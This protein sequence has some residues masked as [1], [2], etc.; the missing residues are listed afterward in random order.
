MRSQTSPL[1][2]HTSFIFLLK[3]GYKIELVERLLEL[4]TLIEGKVDSNFNNVIF[5]TI[6]PKHA[7]ENKFEQA[8]I[9]FIEQLYDICDYISVLFDSQTVIY[10]QE[11]SKVVYNLEREFRALIEISFLKQKGKDW[12]RIFYQDNEKE[13]NRMD[14]RPDVLKKLDNPLDNRD[15]VDLSNFVKRNV[16]T[17]KNTIYQK[18]ERI[19]YLFA[20]YKEDTQS[21]PDNFIHILDNLEE[22]KKA[23]DFK[24]QGLSYNNLYEHLTPALSVEWKELYEKRNL[25]AHNYCLLTIE[26]L[27]RFIYL[28]KIVLRKI[29]TEITLLSILYDDK[30]FIISGD[31]VNVNL[32]KMKSEGTTICKLKIKLNIGPDENHLIEITRATYRDIMNIMRV[33]ADFSNQR[34]LGSLLENISNNPF[35][36]VFLRETIESIINATDFKGK[37]T[38]EFDELKKVIRE[39]IFNEFDLEKVKHSMQKINKKESKMDDDLDTLLQQIF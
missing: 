25:W 36:T 16:S 38:S 22:I 2:C 28:S 5:S 14:K 15:F 18:L 12:Y 37:L 24:N 4:N 35:L 10:M 39:E 34:S 26:E 21:Y 33:F 11:I 17:S 3:K 32:N 13:K 6:Y 19:E 8:K 23:T 27:N 29:R 30:P 7:K 20:Q 1:H 31:V 9:S